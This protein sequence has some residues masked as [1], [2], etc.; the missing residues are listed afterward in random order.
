MIYKRSEQEIKIKVESDDLDV[1]CLHKISIECCLRKI[2]LPT[3]LCRIVKQ[4]LIEM[5][6]IMYFEGQR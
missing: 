1:Q 2:F 3:G 5:S 4:C 6:P